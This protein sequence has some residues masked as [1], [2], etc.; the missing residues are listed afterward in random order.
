MSRAPRLCAFAFAL[1]CAIGSLL[2]VGVAQ[3]QPQLVL[4]ELNE[5]IARGEYRRIEAVLVE[6]GGE[7]IFEQYYGDTT[8]ETRVDAR[9][10]GKS[11]TALAVGVAIDEGA[12][13]GVN[14]R[15]FEILADRAP[16]AHDNTAKREITVQDM[17]TM[18]SALD[19]DDWRDASPGNEERMYRT[20]DWTRFALD[21]PIASGYAREQDGLGR[22]SYCTAGVFLLGRVIERATGQA[23]DQYVQ[24]RIFDRLG[25]EAPQ[26]RRAPNG[27]V[28]SGGQ[29]SLRARDFAALGRL[30]MNR[31]AWGDERVVSRDWLREMLQPRR[32]ATPHD[33]YGYLW[34][35]RDFRTE[36]GVPHPGFYMSGNGGNKIVLLADFDTVIVI[37]S[38]NYNQRDMHQQSTAIIERHI[39]PV[40]EASNA[41][42]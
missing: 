1:A 10:A 32:R 22:F 21:V 12:L 39:L 31:G 33:G 14:A 28:Q 40:F 38:T 25:I 17:L 29:L 9:S 2:S 27:E 11:T 42:D 5:A 4:P 24:E 7:I 36:T 6:R 3:A 41:A 16:F 23:F 15:V 8:A 34:W 30:V 18:T 13:S 26:W 37:L 20:R 19:C 35:V